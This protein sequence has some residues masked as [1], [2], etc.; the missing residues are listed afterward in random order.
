MAKRRKAAAPLAGQKKKSHRTGSRSAGTPAKPKVPSRSPTGRRDTSRRSSLERAQDLAWKAYDT[1]DPERQIFFAEKALELSA[2]CT[3]AY[4]ILARFVRNPMQAL[5]LLEHGL[6]AA[7]RTLGPDKLEKSVGHFWHIVESRPYMRARLAVA[8]CEWSLGRPDNAIAHLFDM[9]RLN[10]SDN[11][12]IR[13][14]LTAHLLEMGLDADFDRLIEKYDESSTFL[15]FSKVLRE[16]RRSGDSLPARKLLTLARAANKHVLPQ[17]LNAGPPPEEL[18]EEYSPG[19][20]N[21]AILY[22]ADFGGGWKQTP[23]ALTW[24]RQ[25]ADSETRKPVKAPVGPTPAAMK[26]L[27]KLPQQYGTIW[28]AVISRVPTWLRD[29]ELMVRPWAMLIVNHTEHQIVGQELVSQEPTAELLFDRLAR[30]MRKPAAGKPHRP[31]EIQVRDEP[32]W[33]AVLPHLEEIGVDC[34][35]RPELEEADFI[36]SELH[37]LMEPQ[38][39]PPGLTEQPTFSSA[40]GASLYEAAAGYFRRRPWRRLPPG[41]IIQVDCPQLGEFGPGRW[42]AVVLGQGGQTFGLAVYDDL[43]AINA[44]CGADCSDDH[45]IDATAL[46]LVF[47][48]KFEIPI[49]DL[50]AAEQHRWPLFGPEAYPLV[51]STSGG[52]NVH[53]MEPWQLQLLEGCVRTIPD[54]LELHPYSHG[55][56]SATVGP[57]APANLKL[58]LSWP[59]IDD[60]GCGEDCQHCESDCDRH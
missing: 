54:F 43:L 55:P 38:G 8:E 21:E 46:S 17:M 12:G 29:G 34:I 32:V 37:K 4:V 49:S 52:M 27:Q 23:G 40:Q 58:V 16:F 53:S 9:L 51:M 44:D 45:P 60:P 13:Y 7:E 31:S 59:A 39:Q 41:A 57:V 56:A 33:N 24:L 2:D 50:L 14:L 48:E 20:A 42:F 6:A 26:P 22:V 30:A 36:L 28:Q 3:D 47:G 10:P 18:P 11:Q 5:D 25:T 19:N 1:S 35:F 15:R